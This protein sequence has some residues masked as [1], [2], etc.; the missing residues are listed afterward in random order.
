MNENKY[1]VVGRCMH[2]VNVI[3][4]MLKDM[5]TEEIKPFRKRDVEQL[6]KNKQL[7]NVKMQMY[8]GNVLLKGRD[9]KLSSLPN[10]TMD[11]ELANQ[12]SV[13]LESNEELRVVA[14]IMTNKNITGYVI[15]LTRDG[16]EVERKS[17]SRDSM[18]QLAKEG[19]VSNIKMQYYNEVPILRGNHCDIAKLPIIRH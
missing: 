13:E 17:I 7:E 18:I 8:N 19:C 11:G 5:N 10:Y 9:C 3:G 16:E 12:K 6:A 4:Y 2:G 1:T 14:R 15:S